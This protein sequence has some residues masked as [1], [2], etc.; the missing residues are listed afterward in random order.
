MAVDGRT[1]A[2]ERVGG[3]ATGER[4]ST[5]RLGLLGRFTLDYGTTAVDVGVAAQRLLAYLG[6]RRHGTRTVVAGTLWPDATEERAHGSLR[7]ALWR[8]HRGRELLVRSEGDTLA[9]AETVS[10]DV[11]ALTDSALHLLDA[12]SADPALARHLLFAGDLLPGWDDD[13][14]LFE[15]ERLRQLRLHALDALAHHHLAQGRPALALEAAL[16]SVRAE[17]LRESAH[18]A[19]VAVHLAEHNVLEAIRHYRAFRSLLE[20]ELGLAPSA[21]FTAML[22]TCLRERA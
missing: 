8:L 21:G 15:R 2:Y 10:V 7:T 20:Q 9:L 22:P 19:V 11:R 12:R 17:P 16:E 1:V 5:P 4:P 6:L 14:V 18:R 3:L 13:W